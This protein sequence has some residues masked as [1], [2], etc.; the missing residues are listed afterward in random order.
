MLSFH[1]YAQKDLHLFKIFNKKGREVSWKKLVKKTISADLVFF[2]EYHDDPIAHYL[3]LQLL[4]ELT[5]IGN[6]IA[7]GL[8]MIEWTDSE[9]LEKYASK[10]ISEQTFIENAHSL[11]SN[12]LTDYAPIVKWAIDN[13]VHV[14]GSNIPRAWASGV[15]KY[16]FIYLDSL[17]SDL[18][19]KLPPLPIPY[20]P[21]LPG[22]K[23]M[24]DMIPGHG[25]ENFPKA[26]AIKDASMAWSIIK[27]LSDGFKILHLNG[28]YHTNNFEGIIWY[29]KQY[30]FTNKMI[31]ITTVRQ[32]QMQK[33]E[34]NH[35]G[36]ADFIIVV[37]SDMIK[38][39]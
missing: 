32:D 4:K 8:E 33:L 38:T 13:D 17:E 35:I 36:K 1:I 21:E 31:S 28:A 25:G 37:P 26:Q 29:V 20:D 39:H 34:K 19:S 3:Q 5:K 15:Y 16:G 24:L 7:L 6:K 23:K 9:L 18:K 27:K 22:Y 11:W 10:A 12:Y 30:G 14:F 2:G